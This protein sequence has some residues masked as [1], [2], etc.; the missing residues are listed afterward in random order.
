MN[1]QMNKIFLFCVPLQMTEELEE[2]H[3][4][5]L[6]SSNTSL[7]ADLETSFSQKLSTMETQL[8]DSTQ[9]HEEE[10]TNLKRLA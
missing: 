8:Q 4:Q 1:E 10:M 6:V 7:Q 5:E 9:Q 3:K 2:T